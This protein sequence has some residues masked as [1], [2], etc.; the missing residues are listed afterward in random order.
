MLREVEICLRVDGV[1]DTRRRL[2]VLFSGCP[3]WLLLLLLLLLWVLLRWCWLHRRKGHILSDALRI[4]IKSLLQL[5]VLVLLVDLLLHLLLLLLLGF[6]PLFFLL[7]GC[8]SLRE[9]LRRRLLGPAP[10]LLQFFVDKADAPAGFLVDLFED[11]DDFFL[12]ATVGEDFA[13]VSE[14]ANG[15]GGDAAKKTRLVVYVEHS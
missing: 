7:R 13:R 10:F 4:E 9:L 5:H 15:Y 8:V 1:Q 6:E 14:G 11:S 2:F 3:R 12:L